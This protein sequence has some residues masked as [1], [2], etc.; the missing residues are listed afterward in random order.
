[1]KR[2]HTCIHKYM[3]V[4]TAQPLSYHSFNPTKNQF[5][6][7]AFSPIHQRGNPTAT[8]QT[9]HLATTQ[10][11]HNH[12]TPTAY[13]E[14]DLQDLRLCLRLRWRDTQK[15]I[16]CSTMEK[17]FRRP[18]RATGNEERTDERK[19]EENTCRQ[20]KTI[21]VILLICLIFFLKGP[22]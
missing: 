17:I 1:M 10:M 21:P 13:N 18:T 7:K 12:P 2:L 16:F 20:K 5:T 9:I 3:C 11:R 4:F 22:I 6:P 15:I 14:P 19:E 8:Q